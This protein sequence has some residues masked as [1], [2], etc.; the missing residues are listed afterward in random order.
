MIAT[1]IQP[2]R[3]RA[4]EMV[5]D[6]WGFEMMKKPF[7]FETGIAPFRAYTIATR[8]KRKKLCILYDLKEAAEIC[9]CTQ[10]KIR[11]AIVEGKIA[12]CQDKYSS[13]ADGKMC[14][15]AVSLWSWLASDNPDRHARWCGG[16]S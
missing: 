15:H 11:A 12:P 10:K 13:V 2:R 14:V 5:S 7:K 8:S 9:G 6:P 1:P 3:C 16:A 4:N